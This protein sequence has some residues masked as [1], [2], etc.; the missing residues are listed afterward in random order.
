MYVNY[1]Y[2]CLKYYKFNKHGK[3]F[4]VRVKIKMSNIIIYYIIII[5]PSYHFVS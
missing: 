5:I 2:S 4:I 3:Q 1:F